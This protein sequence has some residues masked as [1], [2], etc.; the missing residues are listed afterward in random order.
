MLQNSISLQPATCIIFRRNANPR[1]IYTYTHILFHIRIIC[2]LSNGMNNCIFSA[3]MV[4]IT[5][6]LDYLCNV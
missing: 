2:W 4:M 6:Y 5:T 1:F 3:I